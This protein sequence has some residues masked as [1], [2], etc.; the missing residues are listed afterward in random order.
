MSMKP[1][2]LPT[3]KRIIRTLQRLVA[4]LHWSASSG[5]RKSASVGLRRSAPEGGLTKKNKKSIILSED[6]VVV[7]RVW[8][9]FQ[10]VVTKR[11][12][13]TLNS[14]YNLRP[15]GRRSLKM[16]NF[17]FIN[18]N[19]RFATVLAVFAV[20]FTLAACGGGG[21]G[22]DT[23]PV[24]TSYTE[25][26]T[27]PN[28]TVKTSTS[29]T[30]ASAI[31]QATAQCPAP[32]L[33]SVTPAANATGIAVADGFALT[34][35]TDSTL[36]PSS[37]TAAN[38]TLSVG[39]I[40][41]VGTVSSDGTKGFKFTPAAKLLYGQTYTFAASVKD[42][43]G[44]ALAVT[45]SFTTASVTCTAPQVPNAAGDACVTPPSCP[46]PSVWTTG[47]NACV[48][49]VGTKV[50]GAN[51]LPEGCVDW[52]NQC[53]RDSVANGTVKW[54]ATPA[55]M[56]GANSRPIVFAYFIN[57][58]PVSALS[59][60][61]STTI[62]FADNGEALSNNIDRGVIDV[63]DWVYGTPKGLIEHSATDSHCYEMS[64]YPSP[65]NVWNNDLIACP[66][67]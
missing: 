66:A 43:L 51:R 21:G 45:S 29:S 57:V 3:E 5:L 15:L 23:T 14:F 33:V 31:A 12:G 18:K 13:S 56:T 16:K 10:T 44:K 25:N 42:T 39:N 4:F 17:Q 46:A 9:R 24:P 54:I 67:L 22:G 2:K 52:K 11:I 6:F 40:V 20:A 30:Q 19:S 48:Y 62:F 35:A 41:V 26:V 61:Y 7:T 59:G 49:P 36:D 50:V 47:I 34:V 53:W 28:G 65:Y 63:I 55:T 58:A 38:V 8:K 64:W 37:L 32:A 60:P 27:C 1:K